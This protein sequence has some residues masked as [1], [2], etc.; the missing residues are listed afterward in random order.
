MLRK[1]HIVCSVIHMKI[2]GK[3]AIG[4]A[5][6]A[7]VLLGGQTA[8]S[9]STPYHLTVSCHTFGHHRVAV[10]QSHG[11]PLAGVQSEVDVFR[12]IPDHGAVEVRRVAHPNHFYLFG[13]A[14][15]Q[16]VAASW[17]HID[18]PSG[19]LNIDGSVTTHC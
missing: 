17:T 5:L 7:T 19:Q 9:A 18:G 3:A 16:L 10:V 15:G 11:H 8:A 4:A 12:G 13:S 1:R 2:T 14:N 6:A